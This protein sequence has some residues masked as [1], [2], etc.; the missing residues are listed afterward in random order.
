MC[1]V[2]MI[3]GHFQDLWP[4]KYPWIPHNPPVWPYVPD[5][6]P[7]TPSPIDH[8]PKKLPPPEVPVDWTKV[9]PVQVPKE[10]FD[11]LKEDVEEMK[12]LLRRAKIYDEVNGEPNCEIEDKMEFLKQVA[13]LVGINLDDVLK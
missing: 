3:G 12:E 10:D 8:Q 7:W 5:P 4:K 13:K 1:V 2:S 6:E 9:F 11:K